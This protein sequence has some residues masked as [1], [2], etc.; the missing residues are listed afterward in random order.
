MLNSYGAAAGSI[1]FSGAGS[2][3]AS[4]SGTVAVNVANSSTGG[5]YIAPAAGLTKTWS[6]II[7]GGGT[8]AIHKADLGTLVLLP[9]SGSNTYSAA[10]SIDG[11]VLQADFGVGVPNA[12]L[13]VLNGGIW[14]PNSSSAGTFTRGLGSTSSKSRMGQRRRR[15]LGRRRLAD[16]QHRRQRHAQQAYVGQHRGQ[17]HRRHAQVRLD[18]VHQ[19][20]QLPQSGGARWGRSHHQRRR[21]SLLGPRLYPDVRLDHQQHR[22]GRDHQ[23]GQRHL[24]PDLDIQQ[25]QRHHYD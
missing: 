5:I 6:G 15:I 16:D 14:Q 7:S 8:G 3:I 13:L 19:R 24:V 10:T 4:G 21:Q 1:T 20:H 22:H 9:A 12:S 23:D 25:L 2:L 17:Q 11:G 18:H